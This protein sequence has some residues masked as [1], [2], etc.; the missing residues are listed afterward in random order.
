[1][2]VCIYLCL[3]AAIYH[4]FEMSAFKLKYFTKIKLEH[5]VGEGRCQPGS[6][7]TKIEAR[8]KSYF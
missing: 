5:S 2:C 8:V 6:E 1:M 7:M 4:E 3:L